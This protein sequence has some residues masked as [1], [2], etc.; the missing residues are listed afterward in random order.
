MKGLNLLENLLPNF[1]ALRSDLADLDSG[2]S[3][4]KKLVAPVI[5]C[6][7]TCLWKLVCV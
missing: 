4:L 1:G 3:A 6:F 5:W 7:T 2:A